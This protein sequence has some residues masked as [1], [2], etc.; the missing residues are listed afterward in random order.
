[1]ILH[2]LPID[3][4]IQGD[5]IEI[6][7]RFPTNSIDLIFA[8]PPYFLQLRQDLW[9]PNL[10]KVDRVD[11]D[12]DHFA[13]WQT[14]DRFSKDWMTECQRVLKETGTIWVMGTYHNIYRLGALMQDMGFWLL[15]DLVWIK[16]NP[17]PN[18]RGVRF[19]NAHETLL[20][21]SKG[22]KAK[23]TFN[24]HAMK[25]INEGTQMRSDWW[26]PLCSGQERIK[27]NGKKIHS[28]QK[29]QA[30]LYR[31][32]LSSSNPGDIVLD[33][34]FGTGTTGAVAKML[35]RHWIGIEKDPQYIGVANERI[36]NTQSVPYDNNVF[37]VGNIKRRQN[38]LPFSSLIENGLLKPGQQ[39]FF[40]GDR[41]LPADILPD[42]QL[43][44]NGMRGSIHQVGRGLT[45]GS[46]CNGW[47]YWFFETND[48]ELKPIDELRESLRASLKQNEG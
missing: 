16:S 27:V 6:L 45:E 18:F 21:A 23:Y 29:P 31:I 25:S 41:S 36:E 7:R 33:P 4:T 24:Y 13:D 32:I 34:F 14:Y 46:P 39:L 17:M 12:W 28:T 43:T 40:Q 3:Q 5:C 1:M 9:R 10:T 20:W 44:I 48:G 19:T 47:D 42:G 2:E 30:L 38:R 22:K 11:D 26:L 8:D 37:D 35:H 15:N